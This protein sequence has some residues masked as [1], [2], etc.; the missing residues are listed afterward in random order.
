MGKKKKKKDLLNGEILSS[1]KVR[2]NQWN[3]PRY[4][5]GRGKLKG[6]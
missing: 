1:I 6:K 5:E 4:Y 2:R 3:N